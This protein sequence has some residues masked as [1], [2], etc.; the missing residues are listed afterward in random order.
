MTLARSLCMTL[1][2]D[3]RPI[4][5]WPHDQ[6]SFRQF[7]LFEGPPLGSLSGS[8][9]SASLPLFPS[10][11]LLR[12]VRS[13]P[14]LLSS[15]LRQSTAP[16]EPVHQPRTHR[17]EKATMASSGWRRPQG[18]HRVASNVA[19]DSGTVISISSCLPCISALAS[20]ERPRQV[21]THL[22]GRLAY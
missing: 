10:A 2:S 20:R 1:S 21:V 6:H 18:T 22:Q 8:P 13:P 3:H 5:F 19:S 17:R 15:P 11:I 16:A 9:S 7:D 4:S 12:F 14:Y